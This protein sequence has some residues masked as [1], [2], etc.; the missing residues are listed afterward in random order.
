MEH[1][2]AQSDPSAGIVRPAARG[3]DTTRGAGLAEMPL[4]SM[5]GRRTAL[6][7]EATPVA[8]YDE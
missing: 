7:R 1:K 8:L 5:Y 4:S 3:C 6:E 2:R